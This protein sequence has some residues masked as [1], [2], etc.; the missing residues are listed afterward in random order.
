MYSTVCTGAVAGQEV[1]MV[2][3]AVPRAGRGQ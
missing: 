2:M 1:G 3:R